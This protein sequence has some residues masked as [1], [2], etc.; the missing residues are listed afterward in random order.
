MSLGRSGV[1]K[2]GDVGPGGG[3]VFY[4]APSTFASPGSDCGSNCRYLEAAPAPSDGDPALPWATPANRRRSVATAIGIGSGR[5][6]TIA[7]LKQGGD[8]GTAAE[9]AYE[10][11]NGG[12]TDWH[13][14]SET[15][16]NML[17]K[18]R[19]IVGGFAFDLYW[20][21][22]EGSSSSAWLQDFLGGDWDKD[23]FRA[24]T[25]AGRVRPMRA[26]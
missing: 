5:A 22:S 19:E 8:S 23:G 2:V 15:E 26:F 10:Y 18:H 4:V 7:I 12:K 25:L 21:S 13:L 9:Y 24:K 3:I 1:Y 11:V 6:N 16:L 20:S 14:P 17:W